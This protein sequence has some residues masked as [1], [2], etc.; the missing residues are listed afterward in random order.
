VTLQ[1]KAIEKLMVVVKWLMFISLSLIIFDIIAF[2]ILDKQTGRIFNEPLWLNDLIISAIRM[3]AYMSWAAPIFYLYWPQI[4][5]RKR[6]QEISEN[7]NK[8]TIAG[9]TLPS[10]MLSTYL[11]DE[12]Y[13][14]STYIKQ[15]VDKGKLQMKK[16]E[17]A[18]NSLKKRG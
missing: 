15:D 3:I 7:M 9:H 5:S 8:R 17:N 1:N 4:V 12:Q 2:F 11:D 13:G 10:G 16:K 14:A 18:D 6:R